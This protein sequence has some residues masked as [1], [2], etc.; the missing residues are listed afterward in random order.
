M[1]RWVLAVVVACGLVLAGCVGG[2]AGDGAQTTDAT[3]GD[4]PDNATAPETPSTPRER[5]STGE[6]TPKEEAGPDPAEAMPDRDP[7]ETGDG[8]AHFEIQDTAAF[9]FR[10]YVGSAGTCG[11]SAGGVTLPPGTGC[12]FTYNFTLQ[13]G[14]TLV[15][16]ALTWDSDLTNLNLKLL[17]D[18]GASLQESTHGMEAATLPL[19]NSNGSTWEY[20]RFGGD[21]YEPQPMG[22]EVREYNN[23]DPAAVQGYIDRQTGGDGGLPYTLDVWVYTVPQD[24]SHHPDA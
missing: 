8:W 17:D 10:W 7:A 1:D 21:T 16:V 22:I 12:T 18:N 3:D 19:Q 13:E 6:P 15:E 11:S 2:S 4:D 23:W 14:V 20:L 5:N 9:A 24:P